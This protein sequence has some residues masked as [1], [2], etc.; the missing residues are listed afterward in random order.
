[1]NDVVTGPPHTIILRKHAALDM[2]GELPEVLAV[3]LVLSLWAPWASH[4]IGRE[5]TQRA[6]YSWSLSDLPQASC[7]EL[8]ILQNSL[9]VNILI[10]VHNWTSN[11]YVTL[12]T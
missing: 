4:A 3:V 10:L 7:W 5:S 6:R 9:K 11:K 12:D 1:M 2:H 8:D